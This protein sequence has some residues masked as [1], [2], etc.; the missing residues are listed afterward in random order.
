MTRILRKGPPV[1]LLQAAQVPR[2]GKLR[3][4]RSQP[5]LLIH[6]PAVLSH[7][8]LPAYS[9]QV[10]GGVWEHLLPHWLF[11]HFLKFP[12][13]PQRQEGTTRVWRGVTSEGSQEG[14]SQ[15]SPITPQNHCQW[16][17]RGKPEHSPL[18]LK[19][20]KSRNCP[21]AA[22]SLP[23]PSPC[24]AKAPGSGACPCTRT[25]VPEGVGQAVGWLASVLVILGEGERD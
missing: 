20:T 10:G 1:C 13:H 18:T 17:R 8:P 22:C 6:L 12:R 14:N 15:S 9:G 11:P 25:S 16:P 2:R 7:K 5:W 21:A 24:K 19:D 3:P 4:R 23:D